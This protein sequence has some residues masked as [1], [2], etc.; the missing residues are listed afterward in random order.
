MITE[1]ERWINERHIPFIIRGALIEYTRMNIFGAEILK[2]ME[3][4]G[5]GTEAAIDLLLT[6]RLQELT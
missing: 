1:A 2:L 5:L 3:E 6:K 4:K